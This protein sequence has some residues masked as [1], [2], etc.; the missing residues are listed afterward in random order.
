MLPYSSLVS[1]YL[2]LEILPVT[3][4]AT[5][6]VFGPA[7]NCSIVLTVTSGS[8]LTGSSELC[9]PEL[10]CSDWEDDKNPLLPQPTINSE[11][12]TKSNNFFIKTYLAFIFSQM[13]KIK[14][15]GVTAQLV[16]LIS[17]ILWLGNQEEYH[18][19]SMHRFLEIVQAYVQPQNLGFQ[20]NRYDL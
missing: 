2:N 17:F 8:G 5:V 14:K 19:Q 20:T 4:W 9:S 1:L 18:L 16:L 3:R 11:A 13:S 6:F 7:R 12:A 15:S 10:G